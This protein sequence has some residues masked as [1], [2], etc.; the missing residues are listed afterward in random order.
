MKEQI[1][2]K[3]YRA[4]KIM[5]Y[6]KVQE[7]VNKYYEVLWEVAKEFQ[8][9]SPNTPFRVETIY[10]DFLFSPQIKLKYEL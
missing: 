4:D 2:S 9:I 1:T 8:E 5:G 6:T 7:I 3:S 10:G